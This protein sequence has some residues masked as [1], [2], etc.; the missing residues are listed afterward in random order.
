MNNRPQTEANLIIERYC[1]SRKYIEGKV[2][3][4]IYEWHFQWSF[5]KTELII[6]PSLGRALIKDALERFLCNKDYSLETGGV[7]NFTIRA[8]I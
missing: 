3:A 5:G 7:Y 6:T 8:K 4:G 1:F 2:C